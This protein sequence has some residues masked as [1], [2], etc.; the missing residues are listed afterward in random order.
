MK[1]IHLLKF[2]KANEEHVMLL[3]SVIEPRSGILNDA[4]IL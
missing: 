3:P 4:D 1:A 2:G